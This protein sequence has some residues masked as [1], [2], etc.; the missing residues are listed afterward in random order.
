MKR[1]GRGAIPCNGDTPPSVSRQYERS[2]AISMQKPGLDCF[3]AVL[4]AMTTWIHQT[5]SIHKV[6]LRHRQDLGGLAGQE[7]AIRA[8]LIGFGIDLDDGRRIVMDHALLGDAAADI[9]DRV[10]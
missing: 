10:E 6:S 5:A 1:G 3:V 9:L 7:F 4:L 2:E 8:D